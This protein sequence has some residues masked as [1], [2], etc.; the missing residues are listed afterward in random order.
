MATLQACSI[1]EFEDSLCHKTF[2]TRGR[3]GLIEA[4]E[5]PKEE[6]ELL[7]WR[8]GIHKNL[9]TICLHHHN[10][11]LDKFSMLNPYCCDPFW[12]HDDEN[13]SKGKH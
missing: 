10:Q 5:L 6:V 8:T 11:Y 4:S 13:S 1:G 2:H 9:N 12:H 7:I 3:I